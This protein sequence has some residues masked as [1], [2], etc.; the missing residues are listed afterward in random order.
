MAEPEIDLPFYDTVEVDGLTFAVT[1][2]HIGVRTQEDWMQVVADTARQYAEEPVVGIGGHTHQVEDEKFE[3]FEDADIEGSTVRVLNPGSA[4]G[5]DPAD[6]ATMMTAEVAD[7]D[8]RDVTLHE[9][10]DS[11]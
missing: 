5:A 10:A 4:T 2:T 1:H 6:R 11:D 7:G 3:L 8:L 9:V